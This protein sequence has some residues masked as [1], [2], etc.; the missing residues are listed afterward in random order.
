LNR[1]LQR[2]SHKLAKLD[3]AIAHLEHKI[4]STKAE[5]ST[6]ESRNQE[7]KNEI[8][9]VNQ[10]LMATRAHAPDEGTMQKGEL[11]NEFVAFLGLFDKLMDDFHAWYSHFLAKGLSDRRVGMIREHFQGN[12]R[13]K[14]PDKFMELRAGQSSKF[15]TRPLLCHYLCSALSE[16]VFRPF[17]PGKRPDDFD[18]KALCEILRTIQAGE[19]QD[20]AG[21]WR[22]LTYKQA[23]LKEH[24][25]TAWCTDAA[26]W[27]VREAF[28]LMG[29]VTGIEPPDDVFQSALTSTTQIFDAAALFKD[30]AMKIC[31]EVDFLVYVP[32][33]HWKFDQGIMAE[34]C[35]STVAS[36]GVILG[37]GLG[38]QLSCNVQ[39]GSK[40]VREY[41][42][43]ILASAVGE[44]SAL[45]LQAWH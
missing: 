27:F 12:E 20:R 29:L 7:T 35:K 16:Q 1:D 38:L 22:A 9:T 39:N 3:S 6:S 37:V 5:L 28:H 42:F 23:L 21:R 18:S 36:R 15:I 32:E 8:E 45:I 24:R 4:Q 30:K 11:I 43:P 26:T 25:D 31:T 34:A 41:E 19:S 10:D 44:K 33:S 14:D 40:Y 2:E 17:L 13:M